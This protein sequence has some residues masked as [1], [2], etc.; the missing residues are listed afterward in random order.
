M[1][2]LNFFAE[3]GSVHLGVV[4]D[5]SVG[6]LTEM[7]PGDSSFRSL[8][9]WLRAPE[10]IRKSTLESLQRIRSSNMAHRTL[11]HLKRAPLIDADSRIFCVGL[12]YADH[13]AEN[14]LAPRSLRFSSPS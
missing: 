1:K 10:R 14:N 4:Q 3:D 13:A 5:E 12:N 7:F 6:D 9:G 8:T 11:E 2:L